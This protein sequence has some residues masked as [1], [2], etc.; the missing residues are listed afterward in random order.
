MFKRVLL[1]SKGVAET[2]YNNQMITALDTLQDLTE[3]ITKELCRTIRKPGGD[4]PGYQISK[5]SVT[6]LKLFCLLGKAHVAD[7]KRR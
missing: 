6:R 4:V 3:D 1:F 5:L 7:F 2:L